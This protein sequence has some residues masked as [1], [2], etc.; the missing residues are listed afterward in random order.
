MQQSPMKAQVGD[1][2]KTD[3]G[4][5]RVIKADRDSGYELEDGQALA[6]SDI[7]FDDVLL[8]SEVSG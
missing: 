4:L 7:C 2:I 1:F 8:D 6:D 5:R 3:N